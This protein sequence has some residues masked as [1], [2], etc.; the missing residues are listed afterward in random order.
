MCCQPANAILKRQVNP[1]T[2]NVTR[3][4]KKA[5][6]FINVENNDHRSAASPL[7]H[8][9]SE[10]TNQISLLVCN[11]RMST[12]IQQKHNCLESSEQP[13]PPPQKC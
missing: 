11:D 13:P 1:Q 3:E 8:Y 12:Q 5:A 2:A 10:V 4:N 9:R 7:D 6:K